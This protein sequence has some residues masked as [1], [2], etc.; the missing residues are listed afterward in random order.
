MSDTLDARPLVAPPAEPSRSRGPDLLKWSL[1]CAGVGM[2]LFTGIVMFAVIVIPVAFRSLLPSQQERIVQSAPFMRAM[3]PTRAYQPDKVPTAQA[4]R[5]SSTLIALLST[6]TLTI[7]PTPSLPPVLMTSVLVSATPIPQSNVA[8]P[9]FEPSATPL[10]SPTGLP[11]EL[12][13]E[14]P[15]AT[16]IPIP[17]VYH[18][19]G[20]KRVS[21][22]WNDCGPANLT[23]ALQ[24]YGWSGTEDDVR[25]VLKPNREDRNVSPAELVK[26]VRDKTGVRAMSR[27]AG[28]L[29]LI[30]RLI[31]AKFAVLM[32]T[33][34]IV[35]GEGW[36]GHYLTVLGY[37]DNQRI[38]YGGDTNLGFGEDGLGQREGYDDLDR[39]WQQFNRL[40]IVI[41]PQ[42]REPELAAIIGQDADTHYNLEHAL[43]LSRKE[44][45][46]KP[47]S[48]F[49]WFNIGSS[50]T[51]LGEYQ[52]A[53]IA[54]DQSRN[55]G[56]Q[57]DFRMLWYQFTPYQAYYEMGNYQEVLNLVQATLGT[58]K[59]LEESWYW[60]GM[61]EAAKG[62][63]DLAV[64][65]FKDVIDFN[66]GF[67]AARDALARVQNGTF[68]PPVPAKN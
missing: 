34:Y 59:Y 55:T 30:K 53:T 14:P 39:R 10:P 24:Y 22:A 3:M 37:D 67:T 56:T 13:T 17:S 29:M 11:T 58:S 32:E 8:T 65:D 68:A 20:F 61:V 21:Q 47:D 46:A 15:T 28:D 44:A 6:S 38:L 2:L 41:Y 18:A 42:E 50:L 66:P 54:F 35:A 26:F 5:D 52:K 33:G 63:N 16:Q 57:L 43:D 12:P 1:G 9:T 25:T 45:K 7:T 64:K 31:A 4:S 49:A 62:Q 40:Y 27:V 60:R 48:P 51:Q 19:V 36:A 23:Q